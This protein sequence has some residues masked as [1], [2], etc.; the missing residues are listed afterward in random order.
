MVGIPITVENIKT[1]NTVF[2]IKT[3]LHSK[4][5]F[6]NYTQNVMSDFYYKHVEKIFFCKISN[7]LIS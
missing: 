4:I 7:G 3:S 5:D 1:T 2:G 6:F